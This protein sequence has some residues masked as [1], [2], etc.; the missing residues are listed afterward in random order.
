M[1]RSYWVSDFATFRIAVIVFASAICWLAY[2]AHAES[3]AQSSERQTN[4]EQRRLNNPR[5]YEPDCQAPKDSEEA[6]LCAQREMAVAARDLYDISWW[7]LLVSAVGLGAIVVSLKLT[8]D[9]AVA[10]TKSAEIAQSTFVASER[11]W[12]K[13]Q[14]KIAGPLIF[15]DSG[16]GEIQGEINV[17][18]CVSNIGKSP[19]LRVQ[20]FS[21]IQATPFNPFGNLRDEFENELDETIEGVLGATVFPGDTDC[22]YHGL[23]ISSQEIRD[24]KCIFGIAENRKIVAPDILVCVNYINPLTDQ[25]HE[26]G[27]VLHVRQIVGDTNAIDLSVSHVPADNLKLRTAIVGGYVT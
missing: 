8:R 23:I 27:V 22:E 21:K 17:E 11:P 2:P 18:F 24:A 9:A 20:T 6:D 26:T 13:V 15:K 14:A 7:Q 5:L 3:K 16:H 19:A 25:F 10:A 1:S 4:S 12:I